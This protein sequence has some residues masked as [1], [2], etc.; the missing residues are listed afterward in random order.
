MFASFGNPACRDRQEAVSRETRS[1]IAKALGCTESFACSKK[2]STLVSLN[3][4]TY[5]ETYPHGRVVTHDINEACQTDRLPASV[6]PTAS[7]PCA[8]SDSLFRCT[9]YCNEFVPVCLAALIQIL[10]S[11]SVFIT[12]T[13]LVK[14]HPR[15]CRMS[16]C[17]S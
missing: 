2:W 7:L 13:H 9:H 10:V 1:L 17:F 15:T 4:P 5:L 11:H 14:A 6:T 3:T 12:S 8:W 16:S